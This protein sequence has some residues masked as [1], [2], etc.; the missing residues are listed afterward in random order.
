MSAPSNAGKFYRAACIYAGRGWRVLALHTAKDGKCSCGSPACQSQ[1]KHPRYHSQT[2]ADG[3]KSATLDTTT[4]TGWWQLWPETNV[5]IVTG[6]QSGIVVLD[7]DP[8]HGGDDS[9]RDLERANGALPQ[10]PTALTGGGG[11]HYIFAHPGKEIKNSAGRVG[12]GL[13][14]RGDGGYIVAAPSMHASGHAYTWATDAHPADVKPA[15]MPKWLLDLATGGNGETEH[16]VKRAAPLPAMISDGSR[17]NMLTSLAGTLRRRGLEEFTIYKSLQAANAEMCNPPL[18]DDEL[19]KIAESVARYEPAAPLTGAKRGKAEPLTDDVIRDRWLEDHTMTCYAMEDWH[20]YSAG[21]WQRVEEGVIRSEILRV[22]EASREDGVKPSS[23][24]LSSVYELARTKLWTDSKRFDANPDL[25]VCQ[26]GTLH[27]PTLTLQPHDPRHW[28]TTGVDY[29]YDPD[30]TAP[31]WDYFLQST[32]RPDVVQFLQ[33]FAGYA[34]TTDCSLEAAVWLYGPPGSG[35][36]TF[37]EGLEAMLCGRAGLLGLADVMRS[38]FALGGIAGLTLLVAKEQ[39]AG[40]IESSAL[41]NSLISGEKITIERKYAHPYE[42]HPR[43]KLAWAMNELPRIGEATS[44]IFRR[45]KVIKFEARDKDA[46]LPEIKE[47]IRREGAGILN[48]ALVGLARLRAYGG[49]NVPEIIEEWTRHFQET[50]DVPAMFLRDSG[51]LMG[52]Q[53]KA[54]AGDLYAFYKAWCADN[55]HKHQSSTSLSDDW[56]R[57]GL[58]KYKAAGKTIYRG[59]GLPAATFL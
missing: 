33:D 43:A 8:A 39:P 1:G 47:V 28:L 12:P 20:R 44:G 49:F 38:R 42:I 4:I 7:V 6:A 11:T 41:L 40:F 15:P 50:N 32:L 55:G 48:W 24:K 53:Y 19:R 9:L 46:V 2:L 23:G 45:V 36:S 10:T 54:A 52:P 35:K 31:T 29:D 34:L 58:E 17:N 5:G 51:V 13:D 14:I 18:P 25:L 30:A 37:L 56:A 16:E 57:L 26:N 22:I 3:L 21:V 27:I 59:I